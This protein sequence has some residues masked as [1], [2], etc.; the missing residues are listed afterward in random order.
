MLHAVGVAEAD[1]TTVELGTQLR[2]LYDEHYRSLVKLA[3]VYLDDVWTCEEV[4]QDAFRGL[5]RLS[6][7]LEDLR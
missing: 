6:E 1:S 4:V 7:L 5:A 3:S 2:T